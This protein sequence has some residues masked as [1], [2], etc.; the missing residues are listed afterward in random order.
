MQLIVSSS[1]NSS[2]TIIR[3]MELQYTETFTVMYHDRFEFP[4][5]VA[6]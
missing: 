4:I 1:I 5:Y 2:K 3:S 6:S